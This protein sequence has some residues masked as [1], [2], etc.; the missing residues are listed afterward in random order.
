MTAIGDRCNFLICFVSHGWGGAA[1]TLER[2]GKKQTEY[3]KHR[4]NVRRPE[5]GSIRELRYRRTG[6]MILERRYTILK[7][8]F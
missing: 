1:K 2:A 5:P 7:K 4:K 6:I 8:V 3:Y